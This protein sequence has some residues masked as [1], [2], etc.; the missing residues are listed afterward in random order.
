MCMHTIQELYELDE[1]YDLSDMSKAASGHVQ[2]WVG[3]GNWVVC[4]RVQ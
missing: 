2:G 4:G 1:T 3:E